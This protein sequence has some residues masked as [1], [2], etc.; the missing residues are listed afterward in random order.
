MRIALLSLLLSL[1]VVFVL[2]API[3]TQSTLCPSI[4]VELQLRTSPTTPNKFQLVFAA[5][6]DNINTQADF[7]D[8]HMRVN[9]EESVNMRVLTQG[10]LSAN[11]QLKTNQAQIDNINLAPGDT[12]RAYATYSAKGY[13]CDTP[14]HTFSAPEWQETAQNLQQMNQ[15]NRRNRAINTHRTDLNANFNS[16]RYARAHPIETEEFWTQAVAEQNSILSTETP[17]ACPSITADSDVWKIAGLRDTYMLSFENKNPKKQLHYVDLHLST[18]SENGWDNLRL[19]SDMQLNLAHR[20]MQ[21]GVVVRPDE[22][23]K[24][25]WSYRVMDVDGKVIDC[26]T[27][28]S[29]ITPQQI[30]HEIT[31][32]QIEA[33]ARS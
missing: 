8:I 7:V 5:I 26:T 31:L 18:S 12:L 19:A 17:N 24:Y 3:E 33:A 22:A 2:S 25:Y 15:L 11:N 16:N 27:P 21:P 10:I 6:N 23:L 30:T 32:Q 14:V 20:V 9:N 4:P 28:L 1:S 13:A 29:V